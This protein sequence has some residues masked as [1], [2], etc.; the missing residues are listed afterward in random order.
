[1]EGTGNGFHCV[2]A[3]R[4]Q[5]PR[6][7]K[8]GITPWQTALKFGLLTVAICGMNIFLLAIR[9]QITEVCHDPRYTFEKS[10]TRIL[11]RQPPC[12]RCRIVLM[13]DFTYVKP[14]RGGLF[15]P[16]L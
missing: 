13:R 14:I 16:E 5:I 11:H 1:M 10:S 15:R 9:G 12:S 7:A 6:F 4:A 8:T 2:L 3:N